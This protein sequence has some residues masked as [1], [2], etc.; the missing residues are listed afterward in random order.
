MLVT[1]RPEYEH[2]WGGKLF[3]TAINLEPLEADAANDLVQGLV[4]GA[5]AELRA[6][7]VERTDGTPLFIEE[8]VKNLVESG[9]LRLRPGGYE[10]P[11]RSRK[12]GFR[13]R[14]NR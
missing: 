3:L 9:A 8:T 6:L 13:R 14:C 7:I 2:K 4:G 5:N 12:S 10:S 1:C 11:A